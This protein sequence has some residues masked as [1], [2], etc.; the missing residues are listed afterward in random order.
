SLAFA[1]RSVLLQTWVQAEP[2]IPLWEGEV[3]NRRAFLQS[4]TGALLGYSELAFLAGLRPVSAAQARVDPGIVRF[5]PEIEPLVRLLEDTPRARLLE[6][7]GARIR[8]GLTY[9]ESLAAL[10]L[11]GIRNVQPRPA[12]GF[13]FHA[14]MVVHSAHLVAQSSPDADRWL[15]LFW[16]IDHFK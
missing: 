16:A 9:R 10:L 15:P 6:E 11:A 12:V 1:V 5:D 14:V 3:M 8:K 13:K 7:I 2:A 4:G